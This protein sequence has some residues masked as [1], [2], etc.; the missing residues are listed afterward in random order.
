MKRNLRLIIRRILGCREKETINDCVD[1]RKYNLLRKVYK[2]KYKIDDFERLIKKLGIQK[3]DNIF[4]Q[5]S[6]RSFVGFN[7][8]PEDII[9]SLENIIGTKGHLMMPSGS[10]DKECLNIEKDS[11]VMGVITEIFR[12]NDETNRSLDSYFPISIS[13]VNSE[14]I[15][16]NHLNSISPFDKDSPLSYLHQNSG[17]LVFLGMGKI[18]F[19]VSFIHLFTYAMKDKVD[20]YDNCYK[21]YLDTTIIDEKKVY[22]KKLLVRD[23]SVENNNVNIK[24]A[25]KNSSKKTGR[26]GLVDI[27][28]IDT[29]DL[30]NELMKM[31]NKGKHFYKL[32]KK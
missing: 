31:D 26:I 11:S 8:R 27:V 7:G 12:L 6:W 22:N 16:K 24:R 15:S 23:D 19:K 20:F 1:R 10:A 25:V 17:K 29:V 28:I 13:G 18:P 3:S 14:K 4:V 9:M 32:N 30:Y 21:T 5:S 2:K